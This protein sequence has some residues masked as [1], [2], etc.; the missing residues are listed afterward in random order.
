MD[1]SIIKKS[2]TDVLLK[3]VIK[4]LKQRGV[5][6]EDIIASVTKAGVPDNMARSMISRVT[7]ELDIEGVKTS[8]SIVRTEIDSSLFEWGK[9]FETEIN[10][11]LNGFFDDIT[12]L[13]V[14]LS[15]G[16][17]D[18]E[19]WLKELES[20]KSNVKDLNSSVKSFEIYAKEI[21]KALKK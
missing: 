21:L 16:R 11:R 5:A 13:K 6:D 10:E 20:V 19:Q 4:G 14:E 15:R 3:D 18:Q 17:M 7:E 1:L 9:D 12:S 8:K 2:P